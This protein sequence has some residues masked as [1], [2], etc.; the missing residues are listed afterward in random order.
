MNESMP[1]IEPQSNQQDRQPSPKVTLKI[2]FDYHMHSDNSCDCRVSMAAMCR[3]A[4]TKGIPEIAFTEHF[5]EKPEDVCFGRYDPD[6]YFRDLETCRAEFAPQGLTI[7][8]GVEV[9]E[10]HLYQPSVQ[11][12]L[13]SYPYDLVLG[14]LHWSRGESVFSLDYFRARTPD[15]AAHEY[16]TEMIEMIEAGGFDILS[17]LDVIKRYGF[18]VYGKFDTLDYE[19]HIR[20]V[21]AAAIKAGITPEINTSALRMSVNQ[22]HPTAEVIQWYYA[23]GGRTLTIGSDAHSTDDLGTGLEQA[24][25]IARDAGFTH[26]TQFAAR[27]GYPSAAI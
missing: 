6:R 15:Q 1:I 17:H 19:D 11:R 12:V 7:K 26:L 3:A 21:L 16:F 5:D 8:A 18:R 14:S 22:T 9:G 25:Q 20:A 23:M 24:I 2:P 27:K 13:A 4:I 10:G